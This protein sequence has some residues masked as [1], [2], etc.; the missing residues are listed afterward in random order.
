MAKAFL[1]FDGMCWPNPEHAESLDWRV[2]YAPEHLTRGEHLTLAS[3]AAAYC[4]L[5]A[6]PQRKRNRRIAQI[7]A[8]CASSDS[9]KV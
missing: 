5:V 7:R 2:R 8:A 3:I 9:R 1:S 6:M 4:E